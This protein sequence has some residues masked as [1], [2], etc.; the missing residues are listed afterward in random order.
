M[1]KKCNNNFFREVRKK[2]NIRINSATDSISYEQET[3]FYF[4]Q[5]KSGNCSEDDEIT[6]VNP[7]ITVRNF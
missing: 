4:D 2:K 5:E 6:V 7:A 1:H 3:L